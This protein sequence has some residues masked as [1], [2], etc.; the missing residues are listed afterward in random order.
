MRYDHAVMV[1]IEGHE[2]EDRLLRWAAEEAHDRSRPLVVVHVWEWSSVDR[3]ALELAERDPAAA[4]DVPTPAEQLVY[5]AV[6]AVRKD[7]PELRVTGELAYG[8]VTPMLLDAA[9]G[10]S[11]LVV[12]A[13]RLRRVRRPAARLG[14]GAGGR[15]RPRPAGGRA[16]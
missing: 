9:D 6:A 10:A 4:G 1:A 16:G 14:V 5:D 12:G 15:A 11:L 2:A 7:F 13:P 8:R 3:T